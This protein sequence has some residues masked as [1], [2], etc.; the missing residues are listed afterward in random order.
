MIVS[1]IGYNG[2]VGKN[3]KNVLIFSGIE[4]INFIGR[5]TNHEDF[6]SYLSNSDVVIHCA[7]IQ[8]PV[9]DNI[10]SF[11][12]NF[13]LTKLIVD[14]LSESAKLIFISSIH[15]KSNTSFGV[16][17]RMEE[18]YIINKIQNYTIYHLSYTFGAFGKP[19]YNNVFNT[20]IINILNN[21]RIIVNEFTKEFPLM[22]MNSFVEKLTKNLNICLK[23]VDLHNEKSMTLPDFIHHVALIK[24]G[25]DLESD[26]YREI[27]RV[28]AWYRDQ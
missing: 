11:L 14:N 17:R 4:K 3:I 9:I 15:Y 2:Y 19:N 8:R 28:Y 16:V 18:E 26:F 13:E 27:K 1:L 6:I 23:V 22:S 24:K 10:E 25:V 7:A 5:E 21:E 12:P 20:Y